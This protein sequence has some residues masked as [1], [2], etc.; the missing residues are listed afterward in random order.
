MSSEVV[1]LHHPSPNPTPLRVVV[2]GSSQAVLVRPRRTGGGGTYAECLVAELAERGLEADVANEGRWFEMTDHMFR[3]WDEAVAPRMPQV[4]VLHVGFVECQPWVVPHALHRWVL[5]WKTSLHPAARAGRRAVAAPLQRAMQWW[6]PHWTRLVRQH[7]WKQSPR[8][9]RAELERLIG[10][11]RAELGAQVLVLS[12]APRAD[13]W[14][15]ELMPDLPERMARYDAILADVVRSRNDPGVVLVDL[16]AVHADL[17]DAA[18]P[19]GIHLSPA[20]HRQV[21]SLLADEIVTGLAS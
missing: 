20:A 19:D 12:M 16:G 5:A 3:R 9:F 8:R 18:A 15:V 4:V 17:E 21:A 10:Q 7:L 14:L 1:P 6:T 13:D 2:L 11:T